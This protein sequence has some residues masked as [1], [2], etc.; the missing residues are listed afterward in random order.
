MFAPVQLVIN[1]NT[2]MKCRDP[3][4]ELFKPQCRFQN[5]A[6]TNLFRNIVECQTKI[7]SQDQKFETQHMFMLTMTVI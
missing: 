3:A 1:I 6:F 5:K 4:Q 7:W 2:Y